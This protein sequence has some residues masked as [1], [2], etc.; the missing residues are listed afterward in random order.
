MP[1]KKPKPFTILVDTCVWLD[2]ARDHPEQP[3]IAALEDLVKAGKVE[4]ILPQIVVD[5][6]Q[7]NKAR[8]AEETRRSLHSHFQLVREAVNRFGNAASKADTIR[9]LGEV[10]HAIIIKG[11]AV[12]DSIERIDALLKGSSPMPTTNIIKQRVTERAIAIKAPYHRDKNNVGDAIIIETYDEIVS[13]ARRTKRNFA[14]VT[15]NTK[16]FSELNGDRRKPHSDLAGVFPSPRS[17]YWVSMIDVIKTN[18]PRT[19]GRS[20][21]RAKLQ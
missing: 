7:R 20:R 10:D 17:T 21:F 9:A 13:S 19:F 3:V 5:E 16:D 12:N 4:L 15:H 18:R 1:K 2:L 14:F 11:D 6:F 8:V